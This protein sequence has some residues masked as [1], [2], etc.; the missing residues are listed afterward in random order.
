MGQI[1][2]YATF[3]PV[4]ADYILGTDDPGGTPLTRNSTV[5]AL[6]GAMEFGSIYVTGGSGTQA[7]GGA[8]T[9]CTLFNAAAGANGAASAGVTP[10]KANNKITLTNT[11]YY[12]VVAQLSFGNSAAETTS[13]R[14]YWNAVAQTQ[15]TGVL[16]ATAADNTVRNCVTIA[17]V[18]DVTTGAT[19]LDLRVAAASGTLIVYEANLTVVRIG[20]T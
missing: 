6:L 19:D 15:L 8:Y 9:L 3:T 17:G 12:L 13:W 2:D 14:V 7:P 20:N 4:S 10:D 16:D 5:L 1:Q 18:V 11:G